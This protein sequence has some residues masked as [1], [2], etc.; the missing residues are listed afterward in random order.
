MSKTPIVKTSIVYI[1]LGSNLDRPVSQLQKA[2]TALGQLPGTRVLADS[3]YYTSKPMGPEDQPDY[4]NAVVQIETSLLPHALLEQ[5]QAIEHQQGRVKTRHW[6]ERCID[7]DILLYADQQI[8]EPDL[9]IPHPGISQ[10]DFVYKPLLKLHAEIE[11]PGEGLLAVLVEKKKGENP[12]TGYD[13]SF[14]GT[15]E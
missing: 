5:C 3:G 13:C 12:E 4:Y 2:I 1:G 15:L 8:S 10:R 7:V 6:G 14:A 11:I 9:T